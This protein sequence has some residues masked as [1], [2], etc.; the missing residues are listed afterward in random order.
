VRNNGESN[1]VTYLLV[2]ALAA[3]GF[4]AFHVGPL[5][6]DNLEAKE[7]ASEAFSIF[8]LKGEKYARENLLVR[9]NLKS[10]NTSHYEVDKDG[11][12]SVKPGYGLNDDNITFN[13]D[14]TSRKLTIR[15]EYDRIVEFAPLKKRKTYHLIAEK[16]GTLAK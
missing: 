14:E 8:S 4:Y 12:E 7:A 2:I 3:A 9:L 5:Y 10:P 11:L 16:I 15:I 13:F 6:Y 1:P